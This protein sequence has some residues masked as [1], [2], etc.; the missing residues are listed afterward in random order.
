MMKF[1]EPTCVKFF[2]SKGSVAVEVEKGISHTEIEL[3][4]A[5]PHSHPGG[6]VVIVSD[7]KEIGVLEEISSLDPDSR[8]VVEDELSRRYFFPTVKKV[9]RIK[10]EES[11]MTWDVETDR[12]SRNIRTRSYQDSI[13]ELGSKMIL[14]DTD[15]NRYYLTP[16]CLGIRDGRPVQ[17]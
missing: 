2:L 15:G 14:T 1:L 4:K 6:Y 11:G 17:T 16:S 9:N 7:G 12:G 5:F 3:I 8:Q 10:Q 13:T